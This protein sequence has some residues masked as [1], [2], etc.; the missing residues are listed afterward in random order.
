MSKQQVNLKSDEFQPKNE[1]VLVKPE[2]LAEKKTDGGIVIPVANK[3]SVNDRPS[4]GTVISLGSDIE[5]IVE[6]DF[7]MWPNTD[8]LD[9][10]FIDGDFML[11]R[12]K[13]VIGSRK[14]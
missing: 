7:V 5:D 2:V 10:E 14:K 3:T 12:Y 1:Y 8:G 11:I 9:L 4:S 13:S 6:N